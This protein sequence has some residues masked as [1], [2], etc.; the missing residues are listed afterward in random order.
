MH[1]SFDESS[2]FYS[3]YFILLRFA[4]QKLK[5]STKC[6]CEPGEDITSES[7][8]KEALAVRDALFAHRELIDEFVKENSDQLPAD[9]L[10]IVASWKHAVLGKFYI[11]R[12]LTNYTI[13]LTA[14]GSSHKAFG[15]L[16]LADPLEE[17]FGPNLPLLVEATLLPFEGKIIC[18]GLVSGYNITFGGGVKKRLNEEYKQAKEEFGIIT[19]LSVEGEKRE[20]GRK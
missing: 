19:S 4:N 13:F 1:L 5:I 6:F 11:F 15:V 18:D 8:S 2:L 9:A 12:Y 3:L 7:L 16:G 10:E 17:I 14:D 20:I